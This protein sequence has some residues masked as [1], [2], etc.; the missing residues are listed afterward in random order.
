MLGR[1]GEWYGLRNLGV[2]VSGFGPA[3]EFE[4]AMS[5]AGVGPSAIFGFG[6]IAVVGAARDASGTKAKAAASPEGLLNA[7][8]LSY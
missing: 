8:L 2:V 4:P 6:W 7:P 1:A 3:P 5:L